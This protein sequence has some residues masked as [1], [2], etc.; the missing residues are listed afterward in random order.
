MAPVSAPIPDAS[1]PVG[2]W[3]GARTWHVLDVDAPDGQHL[4]AT[5][6][7][8]LASPERPN[9]LWYSLV[10]PSPWTAHA[11]PEMVASTS[12]WKALAESIA[13]QWMG[14]LPG[15]HRLTFED[16]AFLVTVHVAPP[17]DILPA[18]DTPVDAVVLRTDH[19]E[20]WL[21]GLIRLCRPGTRVECTAASPAWQDALTAAGFGVC[22]EASRDSSPDRVVATYTPR[23][24]VGRTWRAAPASAQDR[25]AVVVGAGLAGSAAAWSLAQ[26][27]WTVQVLDAADQPAAGASG[28]PAGVLAPHVSADDAPLS[29]LSRQ[30]LRATVQRA[31]TLLCERHDWGATGVLEHLVEHPRALPTSRPSDPDASSVPWPWMDEWS[32]PASADRLNRAGL[33]S[34]ARGLWHPSGAWIRPAALVRAQLGHSGVRFV[35]G[36]QVAAAR[37]PGD[38]GWEVLDASGRVITTAAVLVLACAFD[39]RR[40]LSELTQGATELPAH[41]LRGQVTLGPMAALGEAVRRRLPPWP[42]NGHGSFVSGVPGLDGEPSWIVGSTFQ[43]GITESV[44]VPEDNEDNRQRLV[45]LLPTLGD[46]WS[47]LG[48]GTPG[49]QGWAGVRCT[50]PDRLPAVGAIDPQRWPG[51]CVLTGLG[52]RGLTLSVLSGEVLAAQLMG[53]PWPVHPRLV[54]RLLAERF[55]GDRPA[56]PRAAKPQSP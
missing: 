8:W 24:P 3:A 6:A 31:R 12:P 56:R 39:A 9:R 7:A 13:S 34:T 15:T 54:R 45:R 17:A 21:K 28:L 2:S 29:H 44:V 52:A 51:L 11:W 19:P 49:I 27:G 37:R 38:A 14:L 10:L 42:V 48:A 43:R 41:P 46:P 55:S 4:L 36:V 20:P 16:G 33:P 26:R 30:G 47:T 40:L 18:L 22:T 5:Y 35:G 50:L 53:E 25:Q 23:W 32:V 1:P